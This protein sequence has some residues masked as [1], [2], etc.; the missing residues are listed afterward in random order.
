MY[1]LL[2]RLAHRAGDRGRAIRIHQ[3]LLLRADLDGSQRQRAVRAL[4]EDLRAE[5]HRRRAIASFE[6]AA[7][8][9]PRDVAVWRHLAELYEEVGDFDQ[10]LAARDRLGRLEGASRAERQRVKAEIGLAKARAARD[11]GRIDEAYRT[12]RKSVSRSGTDPE[13]Y[14]LLGEIEAERGRNKPALAAWKSALEAAPGEGA[15]LY[16]RI[17]SAFAALDRAREYET[18]LRGRLERDP[19]DAGA[20]EAL[21]NALIARGETE[22]GVDELRRVLELAPSRMSA[23]VALGRQLLASDRA[24][25]AMKALS[26]LLALL[27]EDASS[28]DGR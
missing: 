28:E 21:A 1:L 18:W 23:H 16:P 25:D 12:A 8:R 17:A 10:A 19:A 26:E 27:E 20:R 11:A 3:N 13:V 2:G 4:G 7:E 14:V 22:E 6:E 15:V 24:P 5:G 9:S